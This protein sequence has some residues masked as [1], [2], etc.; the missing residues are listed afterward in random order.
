MVRRSLAPFVK[1]CFVVDF[2]HAIGYVSE[3]NLSTWQVD[4]DTLKQAAR[5][6]LLSDGLDLARSGLVTSVLGPEGYV[7]S[8]LAVP[9]ALLSAVDEAVPG[10]VVIAPGRD[11][12]R[13]VSLADPDMLA[14]EV[15]QATAAYL[16]EPRQ[17]SP[18]PYLVEGDRLTPWEPSSGHP[19]AP[20]VQRSHRL[21]DLDEYERQRIVL[22]QML[23]QDVSVASYKLR[24][25]ADGR[26]WSW[27]AWLRDVD[28]ALVPET[29][30][31]FLSDTGHNDAAFLVSWADAVTRRARAGL[32]SRP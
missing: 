17:I 1:L 20:P 9:R 18:A 30:R 4:F 19:A 23:G 29:D 6:N 25:R 7:S 2:D 10:V 31:V 8:W 13:P 32:G 21:L 3:R 12:L 5:D 14:A 26:A 16:N 11:Q 28:D 27:A 24:E 22:Q 15:E